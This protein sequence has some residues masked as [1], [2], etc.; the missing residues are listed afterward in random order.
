[1]NFMK[2]TKSTK[3]LPFSYQGIIIGGVR[4]K[5]HK[6]MICKKQWLID[7]YYSPLAEIMEIIEEQKRKEKQKQMMGN[8]LLLAAFL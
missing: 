4:T 3:L 2:L 5:V 6:I 8:L 7:N 1:M